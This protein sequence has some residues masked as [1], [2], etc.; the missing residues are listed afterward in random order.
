MKEKTHKI[1]TIL[2]ASV[3]IVNG[4]F[5]KVLNF[6]PRHQEIVARILGQSYSEILIIIIGV[7]EILLAFWFLSGIYRK[8]NA[9]LQITLI[10]LMNIIE[11]I[12]ARD[13]LLWGGLNA[14]IAFLFILLIFYNEFILRDQIKDI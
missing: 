11:F 5:A 14:I 2:I 4:L 6:V 8:F 12:L 9:G 3:W 1:L 13:L 10:A 7:G